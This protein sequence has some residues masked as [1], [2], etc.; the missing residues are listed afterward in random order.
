[1]PPSTQTGFIYPGMYRFGGVVNYN[2]IFTD[3][4]TGQITKG[5]YLY[6]F[7]VPHGHD[8]S[9]RVPAPRGRMSLS[10]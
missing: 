1:M 2:G 4:L 7:F 6:Y 8:G 3:P 9:A 5:S 10:L